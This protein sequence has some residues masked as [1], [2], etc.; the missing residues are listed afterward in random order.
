M[1]DRTIPDLDA[2]ARPIAQGLSLRPPQSASLAILGDVV[3][4]VRDELGGLKLADPGDVLRVIQGAYPQVDDFERDFPSLAFALATGV[5]KTRLMGAFIA[6]L[7]A[8]GVSRHFLVLAPNLTIY[9]KLKTDFTPGTPKYVFK[10]VPLFAVAPPV[11]VTGDDYEDGRGVRAE[12]GLGAGQGLL[13][14]EGDTIVNV[15]NISKIN[16]DKDARGV[17]RVRRLQEYIGESYFDYL[18]GLD[19]L[20]LIM[21]EA[22]RYRA[23]AGAN[24]IN[25]LDPILGLELTATPKGTGATGKPF[26]NVVYGYSLGEAMA[27]GFV[28][29]PA[30]VKREN[31]DPKSVSPEELERIMLTDGVTYHEKVKADLEVY[32]RQMDANRVK[33]FVLVVAKDTAHAGAIEDVIKSD[34]FFGGRYRERVIKVH[35]NLK[36]EMKDDAVQHLLAIESPLDSTEIV[37]HVNKL[38]EG[39][40]VTNLFT[41]VPLRASAS[42]ILTEQTIGRGLRLPYVTRTGAESVDTLAI[43]AHERFQAIVD[44]ANDPNSLIRRSFT[45]GDGGDVPSEAERPVHVPSTLETQMTGQQPGFDGNGRGRGFGE[46]GQTRYTPPKPVLTDPADQAAATAIFGVTSRSGATFDITDRSQHGEIIA[47]IWTEAAQ[48]ADLF[49]S[50]TAPDDAQLRTVLE[51]IARHVTGASI[52]IPRIVVV[53]SGEI[54]F[55]YRDFDAEGLNG[56]NFQPLDE[57]LIVQEIRTGKRRPKINAGATRR[58]A[59]P[60]DYILRSMLDHGDVDYDEHAKLLQ[61]LASAVVTRL[62]AYLPDEDAVETDAYQYEKPLAERLVAQLRAHRWETPTEYA[63]TVSLGTATLKPLA[64]TA[65]PGMPLCRYTE[66]PATVADLRRT[67]FTGFT[68]SLYPVQKFDS[69]P[70]RLF[71]GLLETDATVERWIKPARNQLRIE[72]GAGHSYEPDFVVETVDEK[73]LVEIKRSDE[74]DKPEVVAKAKAASDWVTRA[75]AYEREHAGKPWAYLLIPHDDV[76]N[77]SLT[78]LRELHTRA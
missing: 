15:F 49:G 10:G 18:K 12:D 4:R 56:I 29:E 7:R 45:I 41:I 20:V 73:W 1:T 62:R 35:S 69:D 67:L 26:K 68:K 42:E 47:A 2:D 37:I 34:A 21:D 22:H 58:E 63:V 66:R 5:G 31:F 59:R 51:T 28:K 8:T 70:E 75:A 46:T 38:G 60:E 48:S 57:S 71:A 77:S 30:V 3:A 40:D 27:D 53:P 61:K 24:A 23:T 6:Y 39:W 72:W 55:G 64:F 52:S 9:D 43:M 65:A 19:D 11:L 25:A 32:A 54:T 33:P 78:K 76:T 44:R 36:G 16:A 14:L 50:A 17:P 74:R 13:G